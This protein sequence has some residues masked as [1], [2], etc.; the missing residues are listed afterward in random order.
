MPEIITDVESGSSTEPEV[1]PEVEETTPQDPSPEETNEQEQVDPSPEDVK[2][3]GNEEVDETGVSYKNRYM[4]SQRKLDERNTQFNSLET[5]LTQKFE[6]AIAKVVPNQNQPKYSKEELI[7]FKN[8]VDTTPDNK[9]WAEIELDK[10]RSEDTKRLFEVQRDADQKKQKLEN[11]KQM[12]DSQVRSKFP[13]MFNPDGSWNN[14]HPLTQLTGQVFNSDPEYATNPRGLIVAANEA[15]TRYV[16]QQ[17]PNLL[18][19][20]QTQKRKIKKLE[21]A[22]L[23][24]GGGQPV[25]QTTPDS[26]KGAM[27]DLSSTVGRKNKAALKKVMLERSRRA[28]QSTG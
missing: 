13:V 5:N 3:E 22:T 14:N 11:V 20:T 18:K 12:T 16:I 26:L 25:T 9:A 10:V 19:Q 6:D 23:I 24:E 7:R 28:R 2:P 4:E 1:K 8:A 27:G 21:K 17:Q 15:F